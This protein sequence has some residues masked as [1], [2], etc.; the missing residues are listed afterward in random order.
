MSNTIEKSIKAQFAKFF[1]V[2]DW[3][4]FKSAAD[5]YL[6]MAAKLLTKDIKYE[7]NLKKLRR[8]VQKRLYIGIACV[9]YIFEHLTSPKF[10]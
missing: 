1:E 2:S 10:L 8:N 4:N 9:C 7:K 3:T 6:E 5:Y